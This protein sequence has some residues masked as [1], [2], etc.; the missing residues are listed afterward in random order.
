MHV[1][2]SLELSTNVAFIPS[3]VASEQSEEMV[4]AEVDG[5]DPKMTD[6]TIT[7][8]SGHAFVQGM[9]VVLDDAV[10]LV[11]VGSG[12]VFSS[13]SDVVVALSTGEECDGLAPSSVVGE[14]AVVDPP[15]RILSHAIRPKPNGFPH[16]TCSIAGQASVGLMGCIL[17]SK[18]DIVLSCLVLELAWLLAC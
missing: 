6:D 7:A 1:S 2:K 16:G 9:S 11:G 13:P 18:E 12:R 14:E 17:L 3:N 8:K 4:N 5:S 15:R 10:E